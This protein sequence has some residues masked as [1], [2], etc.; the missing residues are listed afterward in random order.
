M[1]DVAMTVPVILALV[2]QHPEGILSWRAGQCLPLI[3]MVNGYDSM[4]DYIFAAEQ[5]DQIRIVN[6][7]DPSGNMILKP[8][9]KI[10]S[11]F[12]AIQTSFEQ[13]APNRR[14]EQ[15][16]ITISESDS[17]ATLQN[18]LC[19]SF[20]NLGTVDEILASKFFPGNPTLPTLDQATAVSRALFVRNI[21]F[22]VKESEVLDY[23]KPFGDIKSHVS[24]IN[25]RG[26]FFVVYYDLRD[27]VRAIDTLGSLEFRGREADLHF[28]VPKEGELPEK[29]QVSPLV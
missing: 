22:S 28:S 15:P 3:Y 27:A 6:R 5:A 11:P 24:L 2:D 25:N 7:N 14:L 13:I 29:A 19:T 12:A 1:G 20:E 8:Y 4:K 9:Q 21:Q 18:D 16:C 23:F 17:G 26:L 10:Y